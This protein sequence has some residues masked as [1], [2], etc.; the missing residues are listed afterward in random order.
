VDAISSALFFK[1]VLEPLEKSE[2]M[3]KAPYVYLLSGNCCLRIDAHAYMYYHDFM[4]KI[5]TAIDEK[6]KRIDHL[7]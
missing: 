4:D 2:D 6:G 1:H 5:I 3:V 7:M